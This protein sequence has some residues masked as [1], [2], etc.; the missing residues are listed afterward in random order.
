MLRLLLP[1]VFLLAAPAPAVAAGDGTACPARVASPSVVAT[2]AVFSPQAI[3]APMRE[4]D[5]RAP[6]AATLA[7]ERQRRFD[8]LLD[9]RPIIADAEFVDLPLA[10]AR[11]D[12]LLNEVPRLGAPL[13]IGE[14]VAADL[15]VAF[16]AGERAEGRGGR[17]GRFAIAADG[18][19]IWE[20]GLRSREADGVRVRFDAVR[21]AA[22][23]TLSVYNEAGQ[24]VGPYRGDAA[25]A[26]R[27]WSGSVFGD[28][29]RV[30][31][32]AP[33]AAALVASRFT[34]AALLHVGP[35]DGALLALRREY[36]VGPEPSDRDFCGTPVPDCTQNA[37]CVLAAE[38][39][40]AAAAKAV[41]NYS[42]VHDD[43]GGAACTGTLLNDTEATGTPWFL[44][45]NHCVAT[46]SEAATIEARFDQRTTTCGGCQM[47]PA[48]TVEGA[49]L[50]A[51]G[52]GL[53]LPDFSLLRLSYLPPGRTLL[54][55]SAT[56][57]ANGVRLYHLS[58]P[59]GSPLAYSYRTLHASDGSV[60]CG[61]ALAP[62]PYLL[63]GGLP[64]WAGAVYPGSSGAAALVLDGSQALVVGQLHGGCLYDPVNLHPCEPAQESTVD[65]SM[66]EQFRYLAPF[67]SG[68]LFADGFEG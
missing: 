29:V 33:D 38:P 61:N 62:Y 15:P 54:G 63:S 60:L 26:G 22:G 34:I 46:A 10:P 30:Q 25:V 5:T 35:R 4:L 47:L 50:L 49:T 44:T 56:R 21:L 27:L 67:L 52:A 58:H 57:P 53:E 40:L 28:A 14:S 12:A 36:R 32:R 3:R 37:T 39:A 42:F 55:W 11:R 68:V 13:H 7:A 1:I 59:L 65:G 16:A 8:A 6:D 9:A 51:T 43:G 48:V 20:I 18:A 31:L 17:S 45:A 64:D 2:S 24:A 66:A 19:R 41:A 23:V